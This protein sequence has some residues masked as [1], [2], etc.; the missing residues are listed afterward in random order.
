M[1]FFFGR[2]ALMGGATIGDLLR[3]DW[4]VDMAEVKPSWFSV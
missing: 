4:K 2:T 1:S 3:G